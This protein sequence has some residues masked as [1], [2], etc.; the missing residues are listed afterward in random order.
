[1][2]I[3]ILEINVILLL[4][5]VKILQEDHRDKDKEIKRNSLLA[6]LVIFLLLCNVEIGRKNIIIAYIPKYK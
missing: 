3:L 2:S 6:V 1:M 5:I 4:S